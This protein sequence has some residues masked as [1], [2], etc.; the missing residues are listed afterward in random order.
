MRFRHLSGT[1]RSTIAAAA[2]ALL[3]AG[4]IAAG[5]NGTDAP[6]DVPLATVA[7]GDF[8]EVLSLRG[9]I[10]AQRAITV[11]APSQAG[12]L[13]ILKVARTGTT[14][15]KGQPVIEFDRATVDQTLREKS[16]ELKKAEAEIDRIVAQRR[17]EAQKLAAEAAKARY[18]AERA[19]LDV[20]EEDFLSRAEVERR[21]LALA[22]AE[23]ALRATGKRIEAERASAAAEVD[24]A[25][26][27]RDKARFEVEQARRQLGALTVFSPADGLVMLMPNW[28]AGGP[29]GN[30]PEFREGD[31]AW[32]GAQ[33]AEIPDLS[34][35][36]LAAKVDEG[37]RTRLRAGLRADIAVEAL[38]GQAF[39]GAIN[40]ISTLTRADFTLWPPTRNFE[41]LMR[42][43]RSDP[44]LRPGMTATARIV[45]DR[46]GGVTLVPVQA[47]FSDSRG[48]IVFV[49]Q[50]GEFEA[51][52]IRVERRG[53]ENAIVAGVAPGDRVALA[54]PP[55]MAQ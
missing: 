13:R 6:T 9:D 4:M 51:R 2:G 35:T 12:D 31:R 47:I 45:L 5:G 54:R 27:K 1:T 48:P 16:S 36:L 34:T 24:S 7:R 41:V 25:R 20:R 49:R 32:P 28:R 38:P 15:R 55:E 23:S 39:A 26:Q 17:L 33:I 18:D 53:P 14:V 52:P 21:R 3:L 40:E 30:A 29:G 46:I 37:D 19:R 22:D 50:R 8:V 43:D 42:M 11:A 10:R 44:R